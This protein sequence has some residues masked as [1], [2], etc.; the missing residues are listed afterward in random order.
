MGIER[1]NEGLILLCALVALVLSYFL[2]NFH[3][4]FNRDTW[5]YAF[6]TYRIIQEQIR[7]GIFPFWNNYEGLGMPLIL[8]GGIDLIFTPLLFFLSAKEHLAIV[9]FIYF[10]LGIYF[11]YLFLRYEGIDKGVAFAGGIVWGTN[12]FFLWHLH[13]LGIQSVCTYIPLVL[14]TV[15]KI[16][17]KSNMH[18]NWILFVLLNT[19]QL[20]YGKW[21][22]YEYSLWAAFLYALCVVDINGKSIKEITLGKCKLLSLLFCGCACA[23]ILIA[24]FSISYVKMIL[25]SYRSSISLPVDYYQFKYLL[26]H[27]LPNTGRYDSRSYISIFVFA[28]AVISLWKPNKLKLFSVILVILYIVFT[29]PFKLYE[30][31]RLLPFHKGNINVVRT[32]VL[33]YFGLSIM[34]SFGLQEFMKGHRD[35]YGKVVFA[36]I[37]MTVICIFLY[38]RKRPLGKWNYSSIL[39]CLGPLAFYGLCGYLRIRMSGVMSSIFVFYICI[40]TLLFSFVFNYKDT[41]DGNLQRLEQTFLK[42]MDSSLFLKLKEVTSGGHNSLGFRAVD[43]D[44]YHPAFLP[45]HLIET[46]NFYSQLAPKALCETAINILGNKACYSCIEKNNLNQGDSINAFYSL[47][48][49]RYFIFNK[50]FCE[51]MMEPNDKGLE[52]VYTNDEACIFRNRNCFEKIRFMGNYI[53][54]SD[55]DE[56]IGYYLKNEIAWFK[57]Y[58]IVDKSPDFGNL[59]V[60]SDSSDISY[61]IRNSLPSYLEIDVSSDSEAMMIVSNAYD[62]DWNVEMDGRKDNLYRVNVLFQGIKI[63]AGTHRY[64]IYYLPKGL[65]LEILLSISTTVLLIVSRKCHFR[66]GFY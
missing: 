17:L 10:L 42:S 32:N 49:V 7:N 45:L 64:V 55:R 34:F 14:L 11:F 60:N 18:R 24:P 58:F 61:E 28:F 2:F 65:L 12:G 43:D 1:K 8:K 48:S 36:F 41:N 54:V 19:L 30:I 66:N 59:S 13:E 38:A 25:N 33:F 37:A 35:K 16:S 26:Q 21:D 15:K 53:I 39:F 44:L 52:L 51:G 62:E 46:T 29:Y 57:K 23:F 20:S 40:Y 9:G 56:R 27:F 22:L 63:R 3:Y 6:T 47:S 5:H 4:S 50:K 31:I